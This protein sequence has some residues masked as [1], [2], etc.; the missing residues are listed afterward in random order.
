MS[1][2]V[3]GERCPAV[4][5]FSKNRRAC[6]HQA[7]HASNPFRLWTAWIRFVLED[8]F[9][10]V[11]SSAELICLLLEGRHGTDNHRDVASSGIFLQLFQ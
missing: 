5:A 8:R 3:K 7:A 4:E 1:E 10:Q 6:S 2:A 11:I 9:E